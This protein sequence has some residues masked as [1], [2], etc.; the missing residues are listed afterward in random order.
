MVWF[1]TIKTQAQP[2]LQ[3]LAIEIT[4]RKTSSVIFPTAIKAVDRGSKDV[5][6][7]KARGIENVLHLKAAR[8]PSPTTNLTVITSDGALYEMTVTFTNT[9][10]QLVYHFPSTP[11][12]EDQY[13]NLIFDVSMT[14][15]DIERAS[16]AIAESKRHM[17]LTTKRYKM[18][19][20]LL[21]VYIHENVSFLHMRIKNRS[22]INYNVQM[23]RFFV[24]DKA[25]LKRTSIQEIGVTP[26]RVLGE[27]QLIK[28]KTSTVLVV[29]LPKF[30]IPDAKKLTWEMVEDHG[31]RNLHL[32]ISNR[33][34]NQ[35]RPIPPAKV[36]NTR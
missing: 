26:I 29:A 30:T 12:S 14:E 1:H 27:Q 21:G 35:A 2:I 33:R 19:S 31:G 23:M 16:E 18:T 6:A 9:P 13:P 15:A 10:R 3:N 4:T 25:G 36:V 5:L 22:F 32:D 24:Q 8:L 34:I 20:E 17:H 7:Q 11:N 28:G